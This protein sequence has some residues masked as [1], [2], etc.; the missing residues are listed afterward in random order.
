MLNTVS[1][2][3]ISFDKNLPPPISKA[4]ASYL[5]AGKLEFEVIFLKD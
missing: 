5:S 4:S 3:D 2:T 1:L